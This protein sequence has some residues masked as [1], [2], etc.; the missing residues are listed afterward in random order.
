MATNPTT[1]EIERGKKGR[2]SRPVTLGKINLLL[3]LLGLLLLI[4]AYRLIL[5]PEALALLILTVSL[6][7][8]LSRAWQPA[9]EDSSMDSFGIP[10]AA[11]C[12]PTCCNA[13][14]IG[15]SGRCSVPP[16]W[17]AR[18]QRSQLASPSSYRCP[19]RTGSPTNRL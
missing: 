6:V 13:S 12:G 14:T 5:L 18:S 1:T 19:C 7:T 10:S 8:L 3:A 2:R 11:N 16:S 9:G 4:G 15:C 17:R